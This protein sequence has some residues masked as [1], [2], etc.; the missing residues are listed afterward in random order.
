MIYFDHS[1][2]TPVT[3][4]VKETIKYYLDYFGNPSSHYG[5]GF[6]AKKLIENARKQ[7]AD[8]INC[9][10]ENIYFTSGGSEGDNWAIKGSLAALDPWI[11]I[12]TFEHHAVENAVY[13]AIWSDASRLSNGDQEIVNIAFKERLKLLR[14]NKQ[15]MIRIDD[16]KQQ[17][18]ALDYRPAIV[19]AMMVNNEIGT[20]QPIKEMANIVA[21]Q[22]LSK[23]IIFHT[24]A[25][26]A[27]GHIPINIKELGV[28]VLTVSGHKFGTP[29]GIGFNYIDDQT[30]FKG[31]QL[32][33]GGHQEGGLRAGT[34]NLPYIMA[35]AQA[36]ET[37][38]K[39]IDTEYVR[40]MRDRLW[41]LI[42]TEIPNVK[43]NGS[44]THRIDSNLNI[45]IQGIDAQQL[46]AMMDTM[47]K[48]C[49]STGSACTS[50]E[51][52]PSHVLK[53]IGL[54][55]EDANSSVRITLGSDNTWEECVQ[56]IKF[57][58]F[59]VGALREE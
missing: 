44:A 22:A 55:D 1:A 31:N 57:L 15:G 32:I 42:Q 53:A 50:G 47:H 36:F 34:E 39:C 12:S 16:F 11:I 23:W 40:S 21:D 18:E 30:F 38:N 48:V 6:E 5:I 33:H 52:T 24:D 13:C 14:P 2:T 19:S 35:V 7:I 56:F 43:L 51:A 54:S 49:I 10:P 37:A 3:D 45:C 9:G 59:D 8:S 27:V 28:N 25:V 20:I 17:M 58:K 29:K 41:D 4:E 26:Q 46:V